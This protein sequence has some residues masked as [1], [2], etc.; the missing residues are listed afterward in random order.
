MEEHDIRYRDVLAWV[1]R[2]LG[3]DPPSVVL[4]SR[5]QM[6]TETT[7]AMLSEDGSSLLLRRDKQTGFDAAFSVAHELRHKWQQQTDPERWFTGY[8]PSADCADADE[9]NLQP[10]ELDAQAYAMLVMITLFNVRPL[11]H[12]LSDRVIAAI[13]RRAEEIIEEEQS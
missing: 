11:F 13:R 9:Y 3:V 7:L 8:R 12:G 2:D 4:R 6:P 10:A 5:R 1:C